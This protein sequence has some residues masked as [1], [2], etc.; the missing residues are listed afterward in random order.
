MNRRVWR[1]ST[2]ALSLGLVWASHANAT[3][4]NFI[5]PAG[6]GSV[7]IQTDLTPLVQPSTKPEGAVFVASGSFGSTATRVGALLERNGSLSDLVALHVEANLQSP[8]LGRLY[9][10]FVSDPLTAVLPDWLSGIPS[11]A[12]IQCIVED[13]T[14]QQI[15]TYGGLT[16]SAQSNS[17]AVPE[18]STLLL[19]GSG[20]AALGIV[21][22]RLRR[23]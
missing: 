23:T 6:G 14:L 22:R 13:G 20:L 21:R 16:V 9:V 15:L 2:I 3:Y 8:S 5:E 18:P 11:C 12:Q 1:V 4:I 7:A 19:L 17:A 10:V